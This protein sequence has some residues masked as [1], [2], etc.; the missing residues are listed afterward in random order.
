MKTHFI[1]HLTLTHSRCTLNGIENIKEVD[2]I[3]QIHE[4]L[5]KLG[6]NKV[7]RIQVFAWSHIIQGNSFFVVSPRKSGKTWSYLPA[8]CHQFYQEAKTTTNPLSI[9]E[10]CYGPASII[11]VPSAIDVEEIFM[12][13]TNLLSIDINF[14]IVT[15]FGIRDLTETKIHLLNGCDLLICTVCSLH[16]L[17]KLNK[18]ENLINGG[19]LK[20][21]IVD[22]MHEMMARCHLEF[23]SVLNDL[24]G[25]CDRVVQKGGDGGQCFRPQFIVTSKDWNE[26][27][28]RLMAATWNPLLVMGD[29]LEAAVYAQTS[30]SVK[31]CSKANKDQELIAFLQ[32][33]LLSTIAGRRTLIVCNDDDQVQHLAKV[34]WQ[35]GFPTIP[36]SNNATEM[37]RRM[38][39]EWQHQEVSSSPLAFQISENL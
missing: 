34:L 11:I 28:T 15:T 4:R 22:N 12:I 19:R 38:V 3:P 7:F 1:Q 9:I 27:L 33:L 30:I 17:L 13:C 36:Y 21:I 6:I 37:D 5:Q 14:K 23:Y 18:E 8:I 31:L 32:R 35:N 26:I 20:R 25:M 10:K 2:F 39:K 24:I 29:F 16:R